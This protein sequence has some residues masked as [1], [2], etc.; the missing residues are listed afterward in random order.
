VIDEAH[1]AI[2]WGHDFRPDY[3]KLGILR[4]HFPTIPL[5]ALTATASTKVRDDCCRIL[6][7]G[8]NGRK[9][10]FFRGKSNRP[11]LN[12]SIVDKPD[13]KKTC[14][15]QMADYIKSNYPNTPSGIIYTFS[16]KEADDIAE[17]L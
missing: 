16:R 12:Y 3:A 6:N 5:I 4:I 11:N 15:Q 7:L 17:K 1:C 14:L 8:K 10:Q 2:Q 9:T 13:C